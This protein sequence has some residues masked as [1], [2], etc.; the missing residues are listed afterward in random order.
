[1]KSSSILSRLRE[2]FPDTTFSML[3]QGETPVDK[4]IGLM[5]PRE[6]DYEMYSVAKQSIRIARHRQTEGKILAINMVPPLRISIH[7]ARETIDEKKLVL[8]TYHNRILSIMVPPTTCDTMIGD[9]LQAGL[10]NLLDP[11]TARPGKEKI[12]EYL[13]VEFKGEIARLLQQAKENRMQ[14]ETK[15]LPVKKFLVTAIEQ[16]QA[17]RVLREERKQGVNRY[18]EEQWSQLQR[19]IPNSLQSVTTDTGNI[20]A[21]TQPVIHQSIYLGIYV[22]TISLKDIQIWIRHLDPK[23]DKNNHAHPHVR[24]NGGICWGNL[25]S[26]VEKYRIEKN[27]VGLVDC[28]IRILHHY[29]PR[30]KYV[31]IEQWGTQ[32]SDKTNLDTECRAQTVTTRAQ[33][34]KCIACRDPGCTG[35]FP[36]ITNFCAKASS[37]WDCMECKID[38]CEQKATA[39]LRCK[40]MMM[41]RGVAYCMLK[42]ERY[43][44][45]Q[46]KVVVQD[47]CSMENKRARGCQAADKCKNSCI[48]T[49]E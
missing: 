18:A 22:I 4:N 9:A 13:E 35:R 31:A 33:A 42:C 16:E 39:Q 15:I 45:C 44:T 21:V 5:F 32:A 14:Y 49:E 48:K 43:D 20:I 10:P 3:A 8:A 47:R 2:I 28:A 23:L 19:Y 7:S 17:A 6:E 40:D 24:D 46:F 26:A 37:P 29:N 1:M 25:S 36:S 27:Y 11:S 38:T 41:D 34:M 12:A 30:D